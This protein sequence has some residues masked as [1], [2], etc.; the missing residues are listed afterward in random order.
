[1]VSVFSIPR[2]A[3]IAAHSPAGPAPTMITSYPLLGRSVIRPE[4]QSWGIPLPRQGARQLRAEAHGLEFDIR[5]LRAGEFLESRLADDCHAVTVAAPLMEQR[6]RRL[7][8][9]L[10]HRRR[11]FRNYR[12]PQGFQGLVGEPV[13]A[14]VEQVPSAGED[15]ATVLGRHGG[16]GRS[17]AVKGGQGRSRAAK[18]GEAGFARPP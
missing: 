4:F 12:T 5:P 7:N 10:P 15:R 2:P 6:S 11:S 3:Y 16:R 14:G 18:G 8:Q 9:P 13:L 17:R 1:M